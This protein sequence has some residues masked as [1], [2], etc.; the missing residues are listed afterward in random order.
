M[1]LMKAVCIHQY[2]GAEVLQVEEVGRPSPGQG[3]VLVRIYAS[4]VNPVDWKIREGRYKMHRL[5]MIPGWD[6]AGVVVETGP[7]VSSFQPKDEVYGRPDISRDGSYAEY[8]VVRASE[9]AL[10]PKSINDIQAAA[11]PLA[12][13]T[14]WQSLF[15]AGGLQPGQHVLI[16]GASGGVGSFAVQLAKWKGAHVIGIASKRNQEFLRQLGADET[17][18]YEAQHFE[19]V[20]SDVDLVL[21]TIGGETQKRSW[22]VLKKGGMLV[23][24]IS[25]P[26][27]EEA[28]AHKVRQ[29]Y[30]FVQ[31]NA[32]EL[33]ELAKLI[34]DGWVMPQVQTILPLSEARRAQELSQTGHTRGKIVL[35]VQ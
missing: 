13:L 1:E 8:I 23:S 22:Q 20:V 30:V 27:E 17:I 24:I 2:G 34:D 18:D 19:K 12:G 3:E 29:A 5:P 16:H 14:A 25:R 15:D 9:I 11:V 4:G 35:A 28:A 21:D 10:K 6:F 32:A 26:S 7:G 33:Q 31:P